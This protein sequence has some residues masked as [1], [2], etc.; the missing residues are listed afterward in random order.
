M[1]FHSIGSRKN[2]SIIDRKHKKGRTYSAF[3]NSLPDDL[4]ND[5]S[6]H[7][8]VESNSKGR[9]YDSWRTN[10]AVVSGKK[11]VVKQKAKNKALLTQKRFVKKLT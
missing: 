3:A 9:I 1:I 4:P 5:E 7:A 8:E 10:R 11:A 2:K 6:N